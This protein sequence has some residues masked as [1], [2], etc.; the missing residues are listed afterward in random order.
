MDFLEQIWLDNPVK[1]YLAVAGVIVF[2]IIL[3]RFIYRYLAGLLFKVV[4][5]IWKDLYKK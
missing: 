5:I 2:V 4:K 1:H 3:K